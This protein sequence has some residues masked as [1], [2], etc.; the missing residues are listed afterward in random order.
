MFYPRT[1]VKLKEEVTPVIESDGTSVPSNLIIT[2]EPGT[3]G[4]VISGVSGT[5]K[6]WPCSF[7]GKK[8]RKHYRNILFDTRT[9]VI[10]VCALEKV[11][12]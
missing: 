6:A 4:L 10:P 9:Y 2:I 5:F 3:I 8:G 1:L 11:D 12:M 7:C